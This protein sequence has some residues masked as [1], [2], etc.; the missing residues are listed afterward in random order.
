M[1]LLNKYLYQVGRHLP[2]KDKEDTINE[3]QS[4]ILDQLDIKLQEGIAEETALVAILTELG[5][6]RSVAFRYRNMTPLLK[7]ELEQVLWQVIKVPAI[8]IP[9][10]LI[11]IRTIE[12][13]SGTSNYTIM[14]VLLQW[15][16]EIPSILTTVIVVMGL[17]FF[18]F[19]ILD[20]YT[21]VD[22]NEVAFT[23][24]P[25][26]LPALPKKVFKA[27]IGE[28][29]ITIIGSVV[30]LYVLNFD[31]GLIAINDLNGIKRGLLNDNFNNILPFLNLNIMLGMGIAIFHLIKRRKNKVSKTAEFIQ[32]MFGAFVL[33]Y[34]A[35]NNIFDA[36]LVADHNLTFL[37]VGF[38]VILYIAAVAAV[39]SAIITYVKMF[40]DKD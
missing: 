39:L 7:R 22:F 3:L 40:L 27:S 23:F 37:K 6:P 28:S 12:F 9:L 15:A 24:D 34:L 16:Y 26:K 32:S 20:R 29:T 1:E 8:I 35:S 36:T 38:R 17:I 30:M 19:L 18:I 5:D 14:D 33:F 11:L 31:Q 4:I 10:V 21:D 13:V 2:T 25:K